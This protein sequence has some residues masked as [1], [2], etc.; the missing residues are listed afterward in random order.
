MRRERERINQAIDAAIDDARTA[1]PTPLGAVMVDL[2]PIIGAAEERLITSYR[3]AFWE[4]GVDTSTEPS[5]KWF[6]LLWVAHLMNLGRLRISD[7]SMD[8]L[9]AVTT[10]LNGA[11]IFKSADSL[12]VID[13]LLV[14][15]YPFM[16]TVVNRARG[17]N[18]LTTDDLANASEPGLPALPSFMGMLM[19]QLYP[20][21]GSRLSTAIPKTKYYALAFYLVDFIISGSPGGLV[22]SPDT[23][24]YD[25]MIG[26]RK[27]HSLV[28]DTP[29]S[30]GP[31]AFTIYISA[32][33]FVSITTSAAAARDAAIDKVKQGAN[34][35]S[36]PYFGSAENSETLLMVAITFYDIR[37][38]KNVL[39]LITRT[40]RLDT[41]KDGLTM[42][43][44]LTRIG[45][46]SSGQTEYLDN[47]RP[48]IAF[49]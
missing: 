9:I 43:E 40:Q 29:S 13:A 24:L 28:G 20:R 35:D 14:N 17:A 12:A 37:L 33:R 5:H 2:A 49:F 23:R 27:L 30:D 46:R 41:G 10:D 26:I 45:N 44:A 15:N 48:L 32:A 3:R 1:S 38:V 25:M 39:R 6:P 19:K 8:E 21:E 22:N 11:G 47:V 18:G 34:P 7:K 4:G 36:I 16:R 42:E 31:D